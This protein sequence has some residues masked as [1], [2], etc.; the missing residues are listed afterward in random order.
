[1]QDEILYICSFFSY[2]FRVMDYSYEFRVMR[3]AMLTVMSLRCKRC[4]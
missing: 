4:G 3:F 1:M 2:E